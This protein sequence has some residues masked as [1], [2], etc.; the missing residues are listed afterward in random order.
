MAC[1]WVT[2]VP[3]MANSLLPCGN[4]LLQFFKPIQYDVDLRRCR[5]L[6]LDGL[7][8]QEAL[9]VGRDIVVVDWDHGRFVPSLEECPGRARSET[10]L[11]GD[12]NRHHL[13]AAAVKKLPPVRIPHRFRAAFRRDLPFPSGARIRLHVNLK[14][15][16]F[17]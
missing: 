3:L 12:L 14:A 4:F 16:G 15:T 9:A 6:L 7:E 17:I 5:L 2:A 8:H 10:R 11:S 13:V 1:W